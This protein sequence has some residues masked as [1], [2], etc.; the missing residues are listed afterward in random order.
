MDIR[1]WKKGQKV[2]TLP[3]ELRKTLRRLPRIVLRSSG[4]VLEV[5]D[6]LYMMLLLVYVYIL[7]AL[8]LFYLACIHVT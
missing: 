1:A 3:W 7:V 6:S 5:N 4:V 2:Q 8:D